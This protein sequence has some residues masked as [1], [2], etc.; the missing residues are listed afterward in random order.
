M[1]LVRS[2][3]GRDAS[4]RRRAR[5][6]QPSVE[7][8]ARFGAACC[9]HS[10]IVALGV[11]RERDYSGRVRFVSPA[12]IACRAF[13]PGSSQASLPTGSRERRSG[14]EM[15][16]LM[17]RLSGRVC[18]KSSDEMRALVCCSSSVRRCCTIPDNTGKYIGC[19]TTWPTVTTR[20]IYNASLNDWPAG[21]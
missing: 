6:L 19:L 17:R 1:A 12:P 5:E 15:L 8:K 14:F 20:Y 18:L 10:E 11:S 2:Q 13:L 4:G 3:Q 21:G 16:D 9:R 7:R